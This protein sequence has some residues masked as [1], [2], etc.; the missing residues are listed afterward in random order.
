MPRFARNTPPGS[1]QHVIARFVDREPGIV[2]NHERAEHVALPRTRT[3]SVAAWLWTG[4]G[5]GYGYGYGSR[6]L[7]MGAR[8][9]PI[10][11][12]LLEAEEV[13]ELDVFA[14]GGL[15]VGHA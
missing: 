6:L 14:A 12:S 2:C 5:Y 10:F 15:G 7:K 8:S 1:L 4:Y 3:R 11:S 9:A 13:A